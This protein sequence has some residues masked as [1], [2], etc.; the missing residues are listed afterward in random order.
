VDYAGE[1]IGPLVED[2]VRS[3]VARIREADVEAVAVSYLWSFK[4]PEHERRTA[5]IL[6]DE[7]PELYISVSHELVPRLGEYERTATTVVN[8]YLG[9]MVQR[10]TDVLHDELGQSQLFLLDSS[11]GV[12]TPAQAGRAPVRLLLS[13]PSGGVTAARFLGAECGHANVITF[14]MGGTSTDV[15]LIDQGEAVQRRETVADKFHLL[16]PMVDVRA[17]GAGG[18]S[19]AR[20]EEGGYL[21]V[22]PESAGADPGPA[23]YGRGGNQPTVTDADVVLGILDPKRFLGG[24]LE[25]DVKR[26]Q[27]AIRTHVAQ[28]LGVSVDEAAVGI[29]RIVDTRMADLLRTVTIEQGHDPRDFILYAFGGAGAT[30]AP[31]FALEVVDELLVPASQ[32][33]FCAVGAVASDIALSAELAVPMRLSR[34][35]HGE[36]IESAEIEGIFTGLE[37]RANAALEAQGVPPEARTLRRLVEVRFVRQPKTLSIPMEGSVSDL[38]D[39]FLVTYSRRYGEESVPESAGFEFVTFVVQTLGALSRPALAR[40]PAEDGSAEAALCG[41]RRAYD[42]G[43]QTF[44]DTAVYD[45]PALRPGH[46]ICGPAVVEYDGTTLS[47]ISGQVARVNEWLGISI[48]RE[49]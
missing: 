40:Y 39:D 26:A 19:I 35:A 22:G 28:P 31:S 45:G 1:V 10:Y 25:I 43:Q 32:S 37:E 11:G 34:D 36:D 41:A 38:L 46:Q 33:V 8:A 17:I 30:H 21:R 6:R 49:P 42:V 48:R 15:A 14:D 9:P 29:K 44:V 7:L 4:N 16:L 24:K 23:C 20:V 47:L 18:G 3:A 27:E 2:D 13:G 5:E 12:M